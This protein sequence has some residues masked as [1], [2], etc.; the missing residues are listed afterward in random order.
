MSEPLK[1]VVE[2]TCFSPPRS[3]GGG[4][5]GGSSSMSGGESVSELSYVLEK[6][7]DEATTKAPPSRGRLGTPSSIANLSSTTTDEGDLTNDSDADSGACSDVGEATAS[8]AG[9]PRRPGDSFSASRVTAR[10]GSGGGGNDDDSTQW[11]QV[12]PADPSCSY[13]PDHLYSSSSDVAA[14]ATKAVVARRRRFRWH[15]FQRHHRDVI[16]PRSVT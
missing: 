5:G 8:T 3:G 6:S 1:I 2:G 4:G 12:L 15:S 16:L 10:H 11:T 9:H 14:A 7:G 13:D